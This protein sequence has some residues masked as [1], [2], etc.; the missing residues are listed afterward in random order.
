MAG[1]QIR[2][3]YQRSGFASLDDLESPHWKE[4]FRKLEEV[5]SDF[6]SYEKLFR[7]PGYRWPRDPLHF[8]A[9]PWEYAYVL[10]HLRDWQAN[11][12]E[13]DRL[14]VMDFGSGVTF[15]PF[16]LARQNM[17]VTAV[18][19]DPIVQN[20]LRKASQ[21]VSASPGTVSF[22]LSREDNAI[23]VGT[24]SFDCVYSVSVLEHIQDRISAAKELMRALK[25]H[26]LLI[27]TFDVCFQGGSEITP[28]HYV[29][30]TN[31]LRDQTE[32]VWPEVSVHP[33]R[34]LSCYNGP[35]PLGGRAPL[36]CKLR[37]W[38]KNCVKRMVGES[39]VPLDCVF[40]GMV[41][42]RT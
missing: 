28:E 17:E 10:S 11:H 15:F 9:R 41:L 8:V 1:S 32:L 30:L 36:S 39:V 42:R 13:I 16:A 27:L 38:S 19:V 18:D 12:P 22:T 7:S 2:Q 35:Y 6:L 25:P 20:D 4:V 26:G 3:W 24:S 40:M 5:Q 21:V 29:L 34:T 31:Y 33:S 37:R 14:K 23:P